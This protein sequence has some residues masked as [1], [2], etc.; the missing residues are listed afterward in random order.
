MA[1]DQFAPTNAGSSPEATESV[2]DLPYFSA[3]MNYLVPT[4]ERAYTDLVD[5]AK[6]N[7]PTEEHAIRV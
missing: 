6:T 5:F 3:S 7:T 1:L 2:V 4:V